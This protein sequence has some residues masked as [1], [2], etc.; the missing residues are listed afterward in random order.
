[1]LS[2]IYLKNIASYN[3]IGTKFR[4]L[5]K[6][7]FIYGNN[8]TGK[9]TLSRAFR[10]IKDEAFS[11]CS[12]EGTIE[13]SLIYN[14]NFIDDNFKSDNDIP[15]IF[16]LGKDDIDKQ[17]E[18]DEIQVSIKKNTDDKITAQNNADIT[19]QQRNESEQKFINLIWKKK[20]DK[21]N[22]LSELYT[23]AFIGFHTSK[24]RF[25]TEYCQQIISNTSELLDS[26]QLFKRAEVIF[27]KEQS[28][29]S[30]IS[31]LHFKYE[32]NSSIFNKSIIGKEDLEYAHLVGELNIHT[33]IHE[34]YKTIQNNTLN[35]CPF[36]RSELKENILNQLS[37]YFNKKFENE[38]IELNKEIVKY[39]EYAES[40]ISHLEYLQDLDNKYL[41]KGTFENILLKIRAKHEENLKYISEKEKAPS[42]KIEL[43]LF[44]SELA[45][46]NVQINIVNGKVENH[47]NTVKKLEEEK[48]IIKKDIW[49]V[50]LNAT[51]T[52]YKEFSS[53]SSQLDK[54]L[55]G[56]NKSITQ[57]NMYIEQD[58]KKGEEIKSSIFGIS[59]TV[60]AINKQ[61]HLYGFKNFSLKATEDEDK[62]K[63]IRENGE[64]ANETLSEGEKTFITFLYYYHIVKSTDSKKII[65]IDDP[66]SSLDST[67]LYIVSTLVKDLI[68]NIDNY[69]IEQLFMV[70]HTR[71]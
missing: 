50:F 33:W 20:T 25:Y 64:D 60:I 35:Y 21:T 28:E 59:S 53:E 37:E 5:K 51:D 42:N 27:S 55:K 63:I 14:K 47:N 19:Q 46:L 52:D 2:S 66:I 57:K 65:F 56:L 15:G 11:D 26:E 68:E 30:T 7:N 45:E 17:R 39:K 44:E 62:Y 70:I 1:M 3:S 10:N 29:I 6:I 12:Y 9:S 49:K 8:G 16:T 22:K 71:A 58:Q 38:I 41:E 34:G 67:I 61:L 24:Q 31:A 36:C 40:L 23:N 13:K 69:K 54:K 48:E 43:N 32:S 4:D 18:L